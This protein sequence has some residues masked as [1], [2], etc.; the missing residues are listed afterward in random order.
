V[1][2][3]LEETPGTTLLDSFEP[4]PNSDGRRPQ[5]LSLGSGAASRSGPSHDDCERRRRTQRDLSATS[6]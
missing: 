5:G 3:Q 2:Q 4:S 6:V 1:E